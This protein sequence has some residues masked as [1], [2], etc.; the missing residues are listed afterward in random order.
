MAGK[1]GFEQLEKAALAQP[2]P[3][4]AGLPSGQAELADIL[5]SRYVR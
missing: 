3:W 2:D 5:L 4:A 1:V